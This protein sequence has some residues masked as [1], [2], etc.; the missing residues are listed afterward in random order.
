ML[1]FRFVTLCQSVIIASVFC[2]KK[3]RESEVVRDMSRLELNL[4]ISRNER[5]N[6]HAVSAKINK[7][8]ELGKQVRSVGLST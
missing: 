8:L 6:I 5:S 4:G 2:Q 7:Y 1:G 3:A